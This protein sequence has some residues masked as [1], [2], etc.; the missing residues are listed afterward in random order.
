MT[1][2]A[3]VGNTAYELIFGGK[4]DLTDTQAEELAAEYSALGLLWKKCKWNGYNCV[5][6]KASPGRFSQFCEKRGS[7][8]K[9]IQDR[10]GYTGFTIALNNRYEPGVTEPDMDFIRGS[11]WKSVVALIDANFKPWWSFW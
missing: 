6:A 2:Y 11:K 8:W 10:V 7:V 9:S 5:I 4:C 1:R 3:Y